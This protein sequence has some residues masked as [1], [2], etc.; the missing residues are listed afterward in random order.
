MAKY[1]NLPHLI[2]QVKN[3]IG[4]KESELARLKET[5]A[6]LNAKSKPAKVEVKAKKVVEVK[7]HKVDTNE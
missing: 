3:E 7:T 6:T 4:L 1:D 5:L 2:N